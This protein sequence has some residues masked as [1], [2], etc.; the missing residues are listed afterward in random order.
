MI[1]KTAR[2]IYN[3]KFTDH[4]TP[5]LK[6]AHFLPIRHRIKFKACMIGYKI[7]NGQAPQYLCQK[8]QM[9]VRT[10]ERELRE[11]FGGRDKFMFSSE[12]W[13]LRSRV[14]SSQI[15]NEWNALPVNI[16]KCKTLETFKTKLK[17]H[18]F[19]DAYP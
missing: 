9:F 11:G 1:N 7:C 19:E 18:F 16:R 3:V 6:L 4:I 5:Y 13:E 17:T 2:F 12:S 14:L 15:K 10:T 8:F